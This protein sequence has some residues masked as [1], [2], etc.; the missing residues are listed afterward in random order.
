VYRVE[1]S[2]WSKG[3]VDDWRSPL[4]VL[5]GRPLSGMEVCLREG[6]LFASNNYPR[7]AFRI[8]SA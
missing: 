7:R 6:G 4:L 2:A 1:K 8:N 3:G 5:R